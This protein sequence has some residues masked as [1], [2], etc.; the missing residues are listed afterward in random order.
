MK[1]RASSPRRPAS[2]TSREW[3]THLFWEALSNVLVQLRGSESGAMLRADSEASGQAEGDC[4]A[5][6]AHVH[7]ESATCLL[8]LTYA[9]PAPVMSTLC[10]QSAA[11]CSRFNQP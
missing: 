7:G 6:H 4:L 11:K 8:V 1:C 3:L 5:A 2:E 9:C 10:S